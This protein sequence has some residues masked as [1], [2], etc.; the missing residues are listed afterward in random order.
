MFPP[1]S[2]AQ[3]NVATHANQKWKHVEWFL[4]TDESR[5]HTYVKAVIKDEGLEIRVD[6]H[7]NST[8]C[9][10]RF[11]PETTKVG[12]CVAIGKTTWF[13]RECIVRGME[14]DMKTYNLFKFNCRTVSFVILTKICRFDP[15]KVEGL[16][17]SLRILCGIDERECLSTTEISHYLEYTKS[18][19][20]KCTLF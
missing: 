20:E 9:F 4:V 12:D 16:F 17:D 19:R 8:L 18:H 14:S 11:V 3:L 13:C 10:E 5:F 2:L 7:D 1:S 15:Q 6:W